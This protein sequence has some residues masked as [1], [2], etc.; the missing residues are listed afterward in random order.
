MSTTPKTFTL[1]LEF[2]GGQMSGVLQYAIVDENGEDAMTRTGKYAGCYMV[3]KGDLFNVEITMTAT[4]DEGITGME[5]LSLDILAVPNVGQTIPA[6][7]PFI[8]EEASIT[9]KGHWSAVEHTSG[10]TIW[11]TTWEGEGDNALKV[12]AKDG[13]F[14]Q[15]A[16]FLA[17]RIDGANGAVV[18]RV[19]SFDPEMTSGG[20]DPD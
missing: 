15:V 11:K 7:N 13:G 1:K 2:D 18:P 12:I 16:G 10:S 9:L 8:L 3:K 17:C 5:A 14:W 19:F 6:F 20:H 4:P